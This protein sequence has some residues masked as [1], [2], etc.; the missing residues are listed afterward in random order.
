MD[1]LGSSSVSFLE[2]ACALATALGLLKAVKY[3]EFDVDR[4][5]AL[6]DYV[7]I[8][9]IAG[10]LSAIAATRVIALPL[11]LALV[12]TI[13]FALLWL[14]AALFRVFTIELGTG[15]LGTVIVSLLYREL[16]E[17]SHA[18]R[19]F[20]AHRA[21]A[22]LPLAVMAA[23]I[24]PAL[25]GEPTA[26]R[27]MGTLFLL[28][29]LALSVAG[30]PLKSKHTLLV[31]LT[32]LALVELARWYA[33]PGTFAVA[34]GLTAGMLAA[35][36]VAW[37]KFGFRTGFLARPAFLLDFWRH[38]RL[39]RAAQFSPR[40]EHAQVLE[41][42]PERARRSERYGSLRGADVVLLTIESL[43][44]DHIRPS[45]PDGA[46][47]PFI[48]TLLESGIR[49]NFH[50]SPSPNTNNAHVALYASDYVRAG[51][52]GAMRP[53]K[54]AG[55]LTAYVSAIKTASYGLRSVLEAAGFD[56]VI[57]HDA[58]VDPEGGRALDDYALLER[59]LDAISR[60]RADRRPLLLHVHTTNTHIPYRVGD[61]GRFNRWQHSEDYGRFKNGLEEA[62][63]L[64][65]S[66][67]ERLAERDILR[68]PL[69]VLSADH[70][71]AFGQFGYQSH[72]SAVIKDEVI[73]PFALVHG[74]LEAGSVA[75]SSHFDVLP[76][77]LDLLGIDSARE[78]FGDSIFLQGRTP[79]L[80][81]W[82]GHP[83][84]SRSSNFGLVLGDRKFMVDLITDK[85][86]EMDWNDN[87]LET[88]SSDEKDY[89]AMLIHR[90]L[91][92]RGL[93]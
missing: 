71:Q 86:Y 16:A 37:S 10:G 82:A 50:F 30:T 55:Y 1:P 49:S 46:H 90:A 47:A 52:D 5:L 65:R 43:G 24:T 63:W 59:G 83:S 20:A 21:F 38:R 32:C 80:L 31:S 28:P 62:D 26:Q 13:A 18:R 75:Y 2:I 73:V 69:I 60:L 36:M 35:K 34:T 54:S 25:I 11:I 33:V 88:K 76:T 41:M 17:L 29:C 3:E 89:Y 27:I 12:G 64:V 93:T 51:L 84:R 87:V 4:R 39:E 8:L 66:F 19:F 77:V 92:A 15:G 58:L 91:C 72:G 56:A 9:A 48:T 57:D 85:C 7:W 23:L 44:R 79:C 6:D 45:S 70:G 40:M 22:L 53:F 67:L 74:D 61:P 42:K 14:D 81:L 78:T 68:E